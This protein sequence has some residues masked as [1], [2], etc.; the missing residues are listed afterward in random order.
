MYITWANVA[1]WINSC[2]AL[3]LPFPTPCFSNKIV[4]DYGLRLFPHLSSPPLLLPLPPPPSHL[5][6]LSCSSHPSCPPG[7][8]CKDKM[9]K[10][11]NKYSQKRNIG[12]SVPISK[13]M[14]LWANHIC[15]RWVCLFCWRKYVEWSWEYINRSETLEC[16]NWGWG[17]AIPRKGIYKRNCRCSA[18]PNSSRPLS[19]PQKN[20]L[21]PP[22]IS[23]CFSPHWGRR[24]QMTGPDRRLA[25]HSC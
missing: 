3:S 5:I 11:W 1:S 13:F 9:P 12:A 17:R 6:T 14:C 8:H 21:M 7:P 10:I 4:Y 19:F 20:A 2:A 23:H 16:G 24:L 18:S 22:D 15:P 25:Q